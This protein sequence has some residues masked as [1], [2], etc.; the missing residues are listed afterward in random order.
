MGARSS[1]IWLVACSR[2][3]AA[4][5]HEGRGCLPHGSFRC[6]LL[7][8]TVYPNHSRLYPPRLLVVNTEAT[9]KNH[10]W[11]ISFILAINM[12]SGGVSTYLWANG[13]VRI[14]A[15]IRVRLSIH[16]HT[17]HSIYIQRTRQY[18]GVPEMDC[19]IIQ[20]WSCLIG[21][22]GKAIFQGLQFWETPKPYSKLVYQNHLP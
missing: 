15:K 9:G 8:I 22:Q 4:S 16:H 19:K 18:K 5:L 10:S 12:V 13:W 1:G 6:I 17:V 2:T 3:M 7:Y 11:L 21:Y 14:G 20:N